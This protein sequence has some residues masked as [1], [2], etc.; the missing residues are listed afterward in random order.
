LV[1]SL[2]IVAEFS[3]VGYSNN[4]NRIRREL[5]MNRTTQNFTLAGMCALGVALSG[6]LSTTT[7]AAAVYYGD[8]G[9]VVP[10]VTF[11]QVTESSG[12]DAVPLYGAPSAYS[13]GVD[14][15]P[16][17]FVATSSGGGADLTDGQLNFTALGGGLVGI[18]GISLFEAGDY[19]LAGMGGPATSVFAGAIL[20]ATVTEINNTSVAPIN[21]VPVNASVGFSLPGNAGITQPW[22]IGMFLDVNAQLA[23]LGY[24]PG[25]FATRIDI[26]IGNT[27]VSTSELGS[28]SFIA[29]RD[30]RVD[31]LPIVVPEPSSMAI[32]GLALGGLLFARRKRA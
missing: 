8:M 7:Q 9:P 18:S 11:L 25:D 4:Q 12:T 30:F 6:M 28:V 5:K 13:T 16:I 21:L 22:S 29:K 10:G 23:S 20:R 14:F 24:T 31:I 27:L 2:T 19:T 17:G 1:F 3:A 32:A 15:A 26:V